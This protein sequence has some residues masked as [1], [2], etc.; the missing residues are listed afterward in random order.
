MLS[1]LFMLLKS[2]SDKGMGLISA[3][4]ALSFFAC[5][6]LDDMGC[7]IFNFKVFFDGIVYAFFRFLLHQ[8][9]KLHHIAV[10]HLL[11]L[12]YLFYLHCLVFVTAVSGNGAP[13]ETRG[14]FR[15]F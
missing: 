10:G 7:V 8:V 3:Q 13:G 12:K 2:I 1:L 6:L 5:I 14:H 15:G 9:G 11:L 4:Y